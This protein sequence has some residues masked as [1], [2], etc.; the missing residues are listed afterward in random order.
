M[1]LYLHSVLSILR[2]I[3]AKEFDYKGKNLDAFISAFFLTVSLAYGSLLEFKKDLKE[4]KWDFKQNAML[5]L[6]LNLL[7][8]YLTEGPN[9]FTRYLK[10][11]RMVRLIH[12]SQDWQAKC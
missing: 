1:P 11:G 7:D 10:P 8:S 9:D 3:G 6:R 12:R 5:N 2:R 4:Q